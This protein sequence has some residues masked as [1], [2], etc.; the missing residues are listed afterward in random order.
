MRAGYA[1]DPERAGIYTA[2]EQQDIY[3][4]NQRVEKARAVLN[5]AADVFG[6][7]QVCWVDGRRG[8]RVLLTAEID[9]YRKLLSEAIE[10]GRPIVEKTAF[11]EAELACRAEE[12]RS[13]TEQLA[14]EGIILTMSGH[15]VDGFVIE[16]LAVDFMRAD[17]VLRDRFGEFATIRYRGASNHTFRPIAFGSWAAEDDRLHVFYGLPHNG[18][19]PGGC[20]AFETDTAVIVAL[21]IK[22]WRGAKTLIGGF[23]PSHATL[24]LTEPLGDRNVNDDADNRARP[25]WTTA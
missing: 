9:R 13:Q 16:Y 22:D 24:R 14:A 4:D 17:R 6:D 20:R 8:V 2:A 21:W 18:E 5:D 12:V 7:L 10:P 11:T 3:G 25:H 23:T 19:K 1:S 15:T